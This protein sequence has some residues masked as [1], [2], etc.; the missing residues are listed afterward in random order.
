M[1]T[2]VLGNT[3]NPG[4]WDCPRDRNQK[5]V[6]EICLDNNCT[7]KIIDNFDMFID[8]CIP[9]EAANDKWKVCIG[10]Y[11][12]AITMLWKKDD[13]S[14]EEIDQFQSNVDIF[15]KCGWNYV[16]TRVSQTTS[17]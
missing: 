8:L 5:V 12:Q 7:R 13:F 2:E 10:F 6:G 15:L 4:Q 14:D 11:Q 9:D 3:D 17:I 16:D 1:N